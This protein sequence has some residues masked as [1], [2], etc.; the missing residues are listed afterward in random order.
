MNL[1][2]VMKLHISLLKKGTNLHINV[3]VTEN[4]CCELVVPIRNLLKNSVDTS[5]RDI[6]NGC[7]FL[8]F[9]C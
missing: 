1:S 4:D 2:L 8:V 3:S 5:V 6:H 9:P 7:S